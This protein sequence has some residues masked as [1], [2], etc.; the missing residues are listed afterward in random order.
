MT[1]SEGSSAGGVPLP[2]STTP[3]MGMNP[4]P[5]GIHEEQDGET[6]PVPVRR[7][8]RAETG[9]MSTP[10]SSRSEIPS[11]LTASDDDTRH[12]TKREL[13]LLRLSVRTT[14][15]SLREYSLKS[16]NG[17]MPWTRSRLIDLPHLRHRPRFNVV[18]LP[19]HVTN[20]RASTTRSSR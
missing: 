19:N 17:A 2:D 5:G 12:A 1:S 7:N 6:T 10:A 13:N 11:I 3:F 20:P 18:H 15:T 9:D 16:S 4:S 14:I 8:F